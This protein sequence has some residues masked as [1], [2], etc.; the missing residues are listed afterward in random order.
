MTLC[1]AFNLKW[2]TTNQSITE[3]LFNLLY[4][5]INGF[6]WS[7]TFT[8][9]TDSLTC[10][11]FPPQLSPW[12]C[13]CYFHLQCQ[14]LYPLCCPCSAWPCCCCCVSSGRNEGWREHT[15]PAQ[16]RRNK[17]EQRD[18]KNLAC[19]YHCPKKSASYD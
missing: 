4:V 19:L 5:I 11:R 15:G 1:Y 17:Q 10:V 9:P 2:K 12:Q 16:R 6:I 7:Y 14:C 18:Q 8:D 13:R 3:T